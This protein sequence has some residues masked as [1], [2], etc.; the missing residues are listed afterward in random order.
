[1]DDILNKLINESATRIQALRRLRILREFVNYRMFDGNVQ[2]DISSLLSSFKKAYLD[3][4]KKEE[5]SLIQKENE[6]DINFL[7]ELDPKIFDQFNSFNITDNL[8]KLE[9][10]I[11]AAKTV[12]L[13]I[14]FDMPNKEVGQLSSWVKGNFGDETL[15]DFKYDHTLIG[16]C[17][18]SY[19]GVL[20]DFSVKAL[21]NQR[22]PEIIK[23]LTT[24]RTQAT[25]QRE[26]QILKEGG[27][28]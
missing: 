26:R 25:P 2:K 10:Q 13:F 24:F 8:K 5:S 14:P 19:K 7:E 1:M 23:A 22:K 9:A 28:I 4:S 21:I 6:K 3:R 18:I 20:K 16:G 15:L 27:A 17:A 12:F 11:Y